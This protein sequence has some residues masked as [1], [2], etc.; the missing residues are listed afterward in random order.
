MYN[1]TKQTYKAKGNG[2]RKFRG[3]AKPTLPEKPVKLTK[4]PKKVV[5]NDDKASDDSNTP[6]EKP[7]KKPS[8]KQPKKTPKRI[9]DTDDDESDNGASAK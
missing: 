6:P 2:I 9:V 1:G 7:S 3:I 4:T 5:H 8:K